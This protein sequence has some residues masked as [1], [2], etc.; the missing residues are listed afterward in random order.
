MAT[1]TSSYHSWKILHSNKVLG[2]KINNYCAYIV[3]EPMH[4]E[5]VIGSYS[6]Y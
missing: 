4:E 3:I 1:S 5:E 2:V 6:N